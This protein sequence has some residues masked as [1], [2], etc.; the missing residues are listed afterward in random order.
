MFPAGVTVCGLPP[1]TSVQ[2]P[3]T[4]SA[5]CSVPVNVIVTPVV[6][7]AMPTE[8]GGAELAGAIN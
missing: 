8:G 4:L 7:C 2:G 5:D 1:V 3:F 6:V